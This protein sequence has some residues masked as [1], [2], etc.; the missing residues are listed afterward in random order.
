MAQCQEQTCTRGCKGGSPTL[1]PL[2]A[3]LARPAR[4]G[5]AVAC[6]ACA[7]VWPAGLLHKGQYASQRIKVTLGCIVKPQLLF[8]L[9]HAGPLRWYAPGT[10]NYK[11][12]TPRRAVPTQRAPPCCLLAPCMLAACAPITQQHTYDDARARRLYNH[13]QSFNSLLAFVKVA[14]RCPPCWRSWKRGGRTH[15]AAR[16][17]HLGASGAAPRVCSTILSVVKPSWH[18]LRG[19]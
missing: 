12:V 7:S 17:P 13:G 1:M 15:V 10:I 11:A 3:S 6:R 8:V 19:A 2:G 16:T 9:S 5:S 4:T 18:A 14:V